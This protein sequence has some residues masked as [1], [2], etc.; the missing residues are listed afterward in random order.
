[1]SN[2]MK[3]LKCDNKT[4][5]VPK[6]D[7]TLCHMKQIKFLTAPFFVALVHKHAQIPSNVRFNSS[8]IIFA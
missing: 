3:H 6:I 7:R 5:S 2:F 4:M 1:M 8:H